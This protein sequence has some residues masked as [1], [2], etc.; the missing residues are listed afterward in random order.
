MV[1]SPTLALTLPSSAT[2]YQVTVSAIDTDGFESAPSQALAITIGE[3][4]I[5]PVG[6]DA[7][8]TEVPARVTTGGVFVAPAGMS[9][10]AGGGAAAD[11]VVLRGAGL[12]TVACT[13]ADG[14]PVAPFAVEVVG[15]VIDVAGTRGDLRLVRGERRSFEIELAGGGAVG[16]AIEVD[17]SAGLP[18][19]MRRLGPT[20]FEVTITASA[21]APERGS[22]TIVAG[23]VP[24]ASRAVTITTRSITAAPIVAGG[25]RWHLGALVGY[26]YLALGAPADLGDPDRAGDELGGGVLGGLRGGWSRGWL[27]LEAEVAVANLAHVTTSDHATMVATRLFAQARRVAGPFTLG[28]ALGAG[29]QSVTSSRGGTHR[30]TD[31]VGSVGVL[32]AYRRGRISYRLDLR[33]DV[34]AATDGIA[35]GADVSIGASF[36]FGR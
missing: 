5:V 14:R 34:F 28:A 7:P 30:D 32:A 21:T 13:T 29:V 4:G 24:L 10:R 11:R 9:C 23:G 36:E 12:T 25:D 18:S 26:H 3:G 16:D 15:A 27:G 8:L 22:I 31:P 6:G 19:S 17:V 2:A 1:P 35:Q 33:Y 20:T